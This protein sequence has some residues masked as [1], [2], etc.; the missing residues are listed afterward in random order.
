ML[1]FGDSATPY[2]VARELGDTEGVLAHGIVTQADAVFV[3]SA[4]VG[5]LLLS[6][7]AF[8]FTF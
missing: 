4:E 2:Q 1:L 7:F 6:N 8:K 3:P 5:P